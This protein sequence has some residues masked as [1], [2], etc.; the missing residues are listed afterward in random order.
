MSR[1][2]CWELAHEQTHSSEDVYG[3][4]RDNKQRKLRVVGMAHMWCCEHSIQGY[5]RR[6]NMP[7]MQTRLFGI[8]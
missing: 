3:E 5:I 6:M 1:I 2:G 4:R 7:Q 8:S